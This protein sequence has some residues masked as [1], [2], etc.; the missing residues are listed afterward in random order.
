M[1]LVEVKVGVLKGDWLSVAI[2]KTTLSPVGEVG[3]KT[4]RGEGK[5]REL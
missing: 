1:P 4:R 3:E 5:A 2:T